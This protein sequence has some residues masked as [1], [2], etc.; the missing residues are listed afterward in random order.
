MQKPEMRPREIE[1]IRKPAVGSRTK[2]TIPRMALLARTFVD[3][4]LHAIGNAIKHALP[5]DNEKTRIIVLENLERLKRHAEEND[6]KLSARDLRKKIKS[7]FSPL[8]FPSEEQLKVEGLLMAEG[9]S[10]TLGWENRKSG[11]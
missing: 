4:P 8:P 2:P 6:I 7:V 3:A 1:I 10:S 11:R 9:C 5:N